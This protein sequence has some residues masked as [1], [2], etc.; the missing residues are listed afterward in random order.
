MGTVQ[1]QRIAG[2]KMPGP[3]GGRCLA[4][5][6]MA[7][8]ESTRS[9]RT[10]G[11]YWSG[12]LPVPAE[13]PRTASWTKPSSSSWKT[14]VFS[15]CGSPQRSLPQGSLSLA[16]ASSTSMWLEPG[17]AM[18]V[19]CP[20]FHSGSAERTSLRK[21]RLW[22]YAEGS[23]SRSRVPPRRGS[24]RCRA[25]SVVRG[26]GTASRSARAWGASPRRCSSTEAS[27][28]T[29]PPAGDS[30]TAVRALAGPQEAST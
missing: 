6:A 14:R 16:S 27:K 30:L 5:Q 4:A 21:A 15:T 26:Q 28:A 22:L 18:T 29:A 23:D 9:L 2:G 24:W 8:P 12:S 19:G 11:K 17:T 13:G 20:A 10:P 1:I 25:A 7:A 3:P